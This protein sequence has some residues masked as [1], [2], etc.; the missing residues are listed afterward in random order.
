MGS[1]VSSTHVVHYWCMT[2][3]DTHVQYK[4]R[5]PPE[6]RESLRDAAE[7]NH[8][9][10]NAEIVARL[11]ESF[12]DEAEMRSAS[13]HHSADLMTDEDFVRM[14]DALM[15]AVDN[16]SNHIKNKGTKK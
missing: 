5:M 15:S 8:R 2:T 1:I 10:V 13:A 4:L 6:L 14:R 9:S 7:K 12:Q 3:H 16:M 11:V